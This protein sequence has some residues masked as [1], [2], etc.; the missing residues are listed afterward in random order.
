VAHEEVAGCPFDRPE[1]VEP[2]VLGAHLP[3]L[4]PLH[5][6]VEHTSET[7]M[8]LVAPSLPALFIEAA[9]G[10]SEVI[11]RHR[12]AR[13]TGDPRLLELKAHDRESLLVDWLNELLYWSEIERAVPAEFEILRIEPDPDNPSELALQARA[14]F[15]PMDGMPGKVKAATLHDLRIEELPGGL[16][17]NVVLDV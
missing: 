4:A 7:E 11:A 13:P 1:P 6:F 15:A 17:A 16:R 3:P 10:L 8:H 5:E 12:R 9:H 2:G 14:R